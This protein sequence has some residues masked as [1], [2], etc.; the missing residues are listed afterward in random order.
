MEGLED[1]TIKQTNSCYNKSKEKSNYNSNSNPLV[2]AV[3]GFVITKV[4][5]TPKVEIDYGTSDIYTQ[6]DMMKLLS[7]KK[8]KIRHMKG[9]ELHKVYY[10]GDKSSNSDSVLKWINELAKRDAWT[11]D[12][13][14]CYIFQK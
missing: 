11:D 3:I 10:A 2:A 14:E 9:F 7:N 5:T 1:N 4:A 13:T 12:F 8:E 6:K